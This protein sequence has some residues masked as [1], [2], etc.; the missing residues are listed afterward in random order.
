M[1]I[2]RDKVSFTDMSAI[3]FVLILEYLGTNS[4]IIQA[5]KKTRTYLD[6]N[7]Y[8]YIITTEK[9]QLPKVSKGTDVV[10]EVKELKDE[11]DKKRAKII[12]K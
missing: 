12:N 1:I 2:V 8:D 11:Y 9:P 5:C 10:A 6:I 4:K 7:E 3:S